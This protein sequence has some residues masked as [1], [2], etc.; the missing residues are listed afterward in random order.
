MMEQVETM[1]VTAEKIRQRTGSDPFFA[2]LRDYVR[3]GSPDMN[4]SEIKPYFTGKTERSVL[5]GCIL[6]GSWVVVPPQAR[7]RL[8][9][10]PDSHP[11]NSRMKTLARSY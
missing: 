1:P 8:R 5:V 3:N 6:W 9:D 2:R 7:K 11:S 4:S 10:L